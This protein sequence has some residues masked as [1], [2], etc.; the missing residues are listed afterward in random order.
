MTKLGRE[1]LITDGRKPE[2]LEDEEVCAI[3][4]PP[5]DW[6]GLN[7]NMITGMCRWRSGSGITAIRL[8]ADHHAYTVLDYNKK[9]GTN[10]KIWSGGKTEPVDW[11]SSASPNVLW[12]NGAAGNR[13]NPLWGHVGGVSDI[14]GY[15]PERIDRYA[16]TDGSRECR[17][18]E[19]VPQYNPDTHVLVKRMTQAE[20][21]HAAK[22]LVIDPRDVVKFARHKGIIKPDP[23]PFERFMAANPDA[24]RDTAEK[25]LAWKEGE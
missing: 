1:I 17:P 11:D 4:Y 7:G 16:H 23:T 8:R 18:V 21:D 10:F 6:L 2:W 19:T 22:L 12:R 20:C 5:G 3:E 14:I 24:D 13:D 9:H 25:A 15:A